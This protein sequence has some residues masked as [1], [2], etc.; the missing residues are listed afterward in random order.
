[1]LCWFRSEHTREISLEISKKK[2]HF[3]QNVTN[4]VMALY[5]QIFDSIHF[6]FIRTFSV[7]TLLD[8]WRNNGIGGHF[9]QSIGYAIYRKLSYESRKYSDVNGFTDGSGDSWSFHW[10]KFARNF[11][12]PHVE[13]VFEELC[14]PRCGTSLQ[15]FHQTIRNVPVKSKWSQCRSAIPLSV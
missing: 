2:V 11:L 8:G 12:P 13:H 14:R 9:D 5:F 6:I 1:M 3:N 7:E 15:H 10:G 4:K